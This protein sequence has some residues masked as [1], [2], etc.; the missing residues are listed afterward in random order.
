[1]AVIPVTET[2]HDLPVN[3]PEEAMVQHPGSWLGDEESCT[4]CMMD[5]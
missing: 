3:G 2:E 4:R 5:I 1:M